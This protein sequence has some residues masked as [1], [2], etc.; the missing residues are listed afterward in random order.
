MKIVFKSFH[1]IDIENLICERKEIPDG[2]NDFI[3]EY[4]GFAN[5]NEHNKKFVADS[6]TVVESIKQMMRNE[7]YDALSDVI[8]D[9]LLEAERIAQGKIYQMGTSVKKG[10]LIQALL[11]NDGE[12]QYVIA[13]VEHTQWVDGEC[14]EMNYGFSAD[15][16]T[17][18][19][20]AVFPFYEI[21]GEI[22]FKD[23]LVYIDNRSKYWY[24]SFLELEEKRDDFSNTYNA[25][26]AV[27]AELKSSVKS[28]SER[29]YV[30]LSDDVQKTMQQSKPFSYEE[31]VNDLMDKYEPSSVDIQKDVLK[32]SLMALPERKHFDT[33]FKT[34]PDS[35]QNKR[36]KKY[37]V[38][39]GID[40]M[41][42][43]DAQDFSK[44]IVSTVENGKR[45]IQIICDD[46]ETYEAF[47][48]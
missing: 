30:V 3:K 27:D 26:K 48:E 10:S 22:F 11:E 46:D 15:K 5:H 38:S 47:S 20:S 35:V 36:T 42:R 24:V 12:Y 4:I 17:I 13:K 7:Q 23:I 32:D 39:N 33:E 31:Y 37:R 2:F 40:L 19:K 41:I 25:Y 21:N 28:I 14:L 29:D 18:W 1:T 45:I 16:K 43:F 6:G 8:A 44:N 9:A 34:I